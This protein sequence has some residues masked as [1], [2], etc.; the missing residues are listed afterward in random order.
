MAAR[1]VEYLQYK[2]QHEEMARLRGFGV[3]PT[4][5]ESAQFKQSEAR[6]LLALDEIA[7]IAA[8]VEFRQLLERPSAETSEAGHQGTQQM[9]KMLLRSR[10]ILDL[11]LLKQRVTDKLEEMIASYENVFNYL[12]KGLQKIESDQTP[13]SGSEEGVP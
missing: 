11:A 3:A 2:E 13:V 6:A 12:D 4:V 5:R 8:T 1:F 7:E 10:E 9:L